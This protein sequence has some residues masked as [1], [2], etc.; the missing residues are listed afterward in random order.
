MINISNGGK[1]ILKQLPPIIYIHAN[2]R[3]QLATRA[4]QSPENKQPHPYLIA[5]HAQSYLIGLEINSQSVNLTL[6]R[7]V[8]SDVS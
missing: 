1:K 4:M 8:R 7:K 6:S 2:T 5:K 3:H